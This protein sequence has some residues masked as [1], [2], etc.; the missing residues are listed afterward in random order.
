ME[1]LTLQD[2]PHRHC[3][4]LHSHKMTSSH[5]V[6]R[7]LANMV[8]A[9]SEI[10]GSPSS[11]PS[12][13]SPPRFLEPA[14][15]APRPS[16]PELY[17]HHAEMSSSRGSVSASHV[18]PLHHIRLLSLPVGYLSPKEDKRPQLVALPP[19][20]SY[21]DRQ[22]TPSPMSRAP[23]S[24]SLRARLQ[25]ASSDEAKEVRDGFATAD[26]H[27]T[28]RTLESKT[29]SSTL[30]DSQNHHMRSSPP[31]QPGEQNFPGKLP[32]FSEVCSL[33]AYTVLY[34]PRTVTDSDS[35]FTQRELLHH[36]GHRRAAMTRPTALRMRNLTLTTLHGQTA[37]VGA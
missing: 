5:S 23:L 16:L 27:A 25:G 11:L 4:P 14:L 29:S 18:P 13:P 33:I 6:E 17:S 8:A 7:P 24:P 10:N 34:R 3:E 35:F 26:T 12:A 30:T 32:S 20:H 9:V 15:S 2:I 28:N 37:S 21:E 31:I 19:P 36:R 22:R 1:Y